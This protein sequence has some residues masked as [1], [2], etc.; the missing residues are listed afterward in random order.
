MAS[1]VG[2]E[3]YPRPKVSLCMMKSHPVRRYAAGV[4]IGIRWVA[5]TASASIGA[6]LKAQ[7]AHAGFARPILEWSQANAWWLLIVLAAAIV[8]GEFAKH[9]FG[10]GKSWKA[11]KKHLEEMRKEIFCDQTYQ[12]DLEQDHRVT[13][14]KK[15]NLFFR[16]TMLG[17]GKEGAYP[18]VRM[19]AGWLCPVERSGHTR[20]SRVSC[21][22]VPDDASRAE[23]VAGKTW[24]N[25]QVVRVEDLPDPAALGGEAAE[26]A[27]TLYAEKTG[28]TKAWVRRQIKRKRPLARAFVGIPVELSGEI[29]GV[30][31]IDSRNPTI[32]STNT[33]EVFKRHA[34]VMQTVLETT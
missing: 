7:P 8:A 14:F 6:S 2:V 3:Y 18:K 32:P 16:F 15:Q 34:R 1:Q 4:A 9:Y 20:R 13:L 31:V 24:G 12:H 21:F 11:V 25:R 26:E 17:S 5:A 33:I 27:I 22:C 29:W 23:G 30:I 28:V 10:A 19:L